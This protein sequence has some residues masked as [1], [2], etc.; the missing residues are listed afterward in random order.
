MGAASALPLYLGNADNTAVMPDRVPQIRAY[1][2]TNVALALSN[3]TALPNPLV[4]SNGLLRI[5]G[6]KA[7]N[8][9]PI[10]FRAIETP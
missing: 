8:V 5:D 6:L 3:W 9:P 7:T 1:S 2:A 10:F 4:L